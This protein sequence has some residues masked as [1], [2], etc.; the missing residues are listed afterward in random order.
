MLTPELLLGE[1]WAWQVKETLHNPQ[2][3]AMGLLLS[4]SAL[5]FEVQM[6]VLG[7]IVHQS[8]SFSGCALW[9]RMMFVKIMRCESLNSEACSLPSCC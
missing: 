6:P 1:T 7:M 9:L 2:T 5:H 8:G 4:G 3:G